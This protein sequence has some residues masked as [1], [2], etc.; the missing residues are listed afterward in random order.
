MSHEAST[1][2]LVSYD[3]KDRLVTQQLYEK[4]HIA[5]LEGG[6]LNEEFLKQLNGDQLAKLQQI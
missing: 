3:S 6:S 5:S 2:G 1:D 4:I